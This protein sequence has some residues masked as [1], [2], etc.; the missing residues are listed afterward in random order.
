MYLFCQNAEIKRKEGMDWI[1]RQCAHLFSQLDCRETEAKLVS[2]LLQ[3]NQHETRALLSRIQQIGRTLH[4]THNRNISDALSSDA[5]D[6][7][8]E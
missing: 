3:Q 8:C 1:G 2:L 4:P 5:I 6:A 7:Q